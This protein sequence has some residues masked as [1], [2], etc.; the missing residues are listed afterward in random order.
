MINR[1]PTEDINVASLVPIVA[2][3]DLKQVFPAPIGAYDMVARARQEISSAVNGQPARKVAIVGP[4]SIHDPAAALDYAR[5]LADLARRVE[6]RLLVVM[7]MYFEKPRTTVGWKGLISDPDLDDTNHISKGLGIARQLLCE[8]AALGLPVATETLSPT[9]PQYYADLIAWGGIG[10]RTTQSQTHREVVSGLSYP[11][12]FKNPTSGNL[13]VAL[14]AMQAARHGHT[15]TGISHDGRAAVIATR[16]NPNVHLVLR[17]SDQGPNFERTHVAA[18][19][20]ELAAK[21]LPPGILIDCS[22][23]NSLKDHTRQEGVLDAVLDQLRANEHG[24]FGFM[25][26]SFLVAGNQPLQS[27][28]SGGLTYGQSITDKCLDWPTTERLLL[29]AHAALG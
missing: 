4:C 24:V 1:R 15:F 20:A 25:L 10:A 23:G 28:A 9:N 5:R 14:D 6:D 3:E 18:A 12:G 27:L 21:K 29:K 22:H 19:A 8:A 13:D 17:G 7:R 16:G 26:E 2:A 11:V